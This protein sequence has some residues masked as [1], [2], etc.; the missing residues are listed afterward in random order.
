MHSSGVH[1]EEYKAIAE[2]ESVLKRRI[3]DSWNPDQ[4]RILKIWAEKASGWAWLHDKSSRY[5]NNLSN[6]IMYPSI[7]LS[8]ISGGVALSTYNTP[9]PSNF[10]T[11]T[12]GALN[13]L[14]ASLAS[15][16]KFIRSAEKA[17]THNHMNKMFS[18]Y[19]RRIV[20]ELA[21][22]TS[23]RKDCLEFC[24]LCRDEYD[25]L[26]NDSPQIPNH[27]VENFKTTFKGN[28]HSPEVVNGLVHFHDFRSTQEGIEF[29]KRKSHEFTKRRTAL[30]NRMREDSSRSIIPLAP[31]APR[32]KMES[33]RAGLPKVS[34]ERRDASIDEK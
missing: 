11:V 30:Y 27:I 10:L 12:I 8:T 29:E 14:S 17:E 7:L 25:N 33:F 3:A 15:I 9:T 20:M 4:E 32:M 31:H 13:L 2:Y 34:V 1:L 28:E 5:Y 22:Q 6:K 19:Y 26:V 24:R 23:D 16:Q 21:L 18:S